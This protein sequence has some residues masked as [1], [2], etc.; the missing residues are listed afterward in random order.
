MAEIQV[1]EDLRI[2]KTRE[3]LMHALLDLMQD[4]SLK[5]ITVR[6]IC[7]KARCSRN[8][9]YN[10]Y[11]YKEDLFDQVLNHVF[12]HMKMA[13]SPIVSHPSQMDDKVIRTYV[14]NIFDNFQA[15][16]HVIRAMK[17]ND[18]STAHTKLF[19]LVYKNIIGMAP[20]LIA[21]DGPYEIR[22][23]L[24]YLVHVITGFMMEW[25][26][27]PQGTESDAKEYLFKIHRE[28]VRMIG[29]EMLKYLTP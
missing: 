20:Q 6:D 15:V 26:T 4:K 24:L 10:H 16:A 21:D 13:F 14:N 11:A 23:Y 28:P 12:A 19:E 8:T 18:A 1:K 2:I 5:D 27:N 7:N 17:A 25:L 22:L 3:N 9:F 29:Q